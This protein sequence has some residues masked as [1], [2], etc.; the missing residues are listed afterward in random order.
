MLASE[1]IVVAGLVESCFLPCYGPIAGV[2]TVQLVLV[3]GAACPFCVY[4]GGE[5]CCYRTFDFK[6]KD[7]AVAFVFS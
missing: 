2:T 7:M 3:T 5:E 1:F 6:S 4:S